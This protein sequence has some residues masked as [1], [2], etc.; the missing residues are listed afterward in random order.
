M[1]GLDDTDIVAFGGRLEEVVADAEAIVPL[2]FIPAFPIFPPETSWM[3][4]SATDHPAL[5][6]PPVAQSAGRVAYRASDLDRCL[7]RDDQRDHAT[8]LA[9]IVRWAVGEDMPLAVS[10]PGLVDCNL[11]RQNARRILHLGNVGATSPIPGR[12][13]DLVPVGPLQVRV[14][15]DMP[16]GD[17]K[18]RLLVA[19]TDVPANASDG[20]VSFTVPRIVDHEVAVIG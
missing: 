17:T 14:R 9:N 6:L 1:D 4:Q 16:D 11:Y 10:G 8:L 13:A 2:T 3:R 20:W 5:V 19:E 18:I 12:Q 7:G 15:A